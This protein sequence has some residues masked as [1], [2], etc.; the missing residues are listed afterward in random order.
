MLI[1]RGLILERVI[2]NSR[3]FTDEE[4]DELFKVDTST[5]ECRQSY[6]ELKMGKSIKDFLILGGDC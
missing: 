2:E 3:I 4:I 1:Q 6:E 5:K